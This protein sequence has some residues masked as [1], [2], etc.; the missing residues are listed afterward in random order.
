M[1]TQPIPSGVV[2]NGYPHRCGHPYL[3][4]GT[5][6]GNRAR[7]ELPVG[8][9]GPVMPQTRHTGRDEHGHWRTWEG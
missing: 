6:R 2:V 7:C 4:T 3:P 5:D 8:H 1:I 9:D